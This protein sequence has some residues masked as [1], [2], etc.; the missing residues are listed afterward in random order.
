MQQNPDCWAWQLNHQLQCT[1]L[2]KIW[3]QDIISLS[4]MLGVGFR[5]VNA[6]LPA[7]YTNLQIALGRWLDKSIC[8]VLD[9]GNL[10]QMVLFTLA[11]L[12]SVAHLQRK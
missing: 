1:A 3:N 11:A 10:C 5:Y 12:P 4:A 8:P 9:L 6:A 2:N 7:W